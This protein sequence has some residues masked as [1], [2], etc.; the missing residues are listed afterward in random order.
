MDKRRFDAWVHFVF[1]REHTVY[2][3]DSDEDPE[4]HTDAI[5]TADRVS[6]L[7]ERCA[8]VLA[9]FSNVQIG[10]GLR[11]LVTYESNVPES[12][13][14]D[15]L[16][17]AAKLRFIE[18]LRP[19]YF[20]CLA[21][22]CASDLSHLNENSGNRLNEIC[23]MLWDVTPLTY[24]NDNKQCTAALIAVLGDV[25]VLSDNPACVE[26]AIHGLGHLFDKMPSA[27]CD[28][29]DRYLATPPSDARLG[30]YA[31]QARTGMI[32]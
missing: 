17:I 16:P 10:V 19:L 28:A 8:D 31:R 9:P 18:S 30:R 3:P 6:H 12:F 4:H 13:R 26:S 14:S 15:D 1:E 11:Y 29:I 24:W 7:F 27:V 32:Q 20:E 25:A 2:G 21:P 23:Y 5:E 22:R